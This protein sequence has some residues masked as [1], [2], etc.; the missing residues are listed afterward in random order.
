LIGANNE[1]V[2]MKLNKYFFLVLLITTQSFA[3][4]FSKFN[5]S[6][7]PFDSDAYIDFTEIKGDK[8]FGF[9]VITLYDFESITSAQM[10]GL[11]NINQLE[12]DCQKGTIRMIKDIWTEK[13]MGKGKITYSEGPFQKVS[14]KEFFEGTFERKIFVYLC[15]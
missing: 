7:L 8:V 6:R 2:Y 4:N 15:K 9:K 3:Q 12:L 14:V 10:W 11:S 5:W 1:I 13:R